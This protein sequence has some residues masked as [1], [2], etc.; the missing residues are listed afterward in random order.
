ML[1]MD[2]TII[3]DAAMELA[4]DT[5]EQPEALNVAGRIL[6]TCWLW[7]WA[8]TKRKFK[9]F[10]EIYPY[11]WERAK[12]KVK[13]GQF[14]SIGGSWVEHDTTLPCGKS[15]DNTALMAFGKGDGRGGPT[16]QHLERM[17]RLRVLRPKAPS[18]VTWYGELYFELHRG[19]YTTQARTKL[20][21]RSSEILLHDIE[22]LA[23]IASIQ[24]KG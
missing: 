11:G 1:H 22:L 17:R 15:L 24:D 21:N 20:H 6:D 10:K 8:E 7:P 3:S 13:S 18:L 16:W 19:V 23:T 9:W 2:F 4:E 12:A 5:C 14:H